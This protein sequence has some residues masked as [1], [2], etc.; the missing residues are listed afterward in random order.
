MGLAYSVSI[1]CLMNV[2]LFDIYD[3]VFPHVQYVKQRPQA[4]LYFHAALSG[5][6]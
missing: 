6:Y 4:Y 3:A 1:Y 5:D 2:T